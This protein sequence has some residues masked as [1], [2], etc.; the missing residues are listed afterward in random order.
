[1]ADITGPAHIIGRVAIGLPTSVATVLS[2]PLLSSILQQFPDSPGFFESLWAIYM[3]LSFGIGWSWRYSTRT[4]PA[5][6]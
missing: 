2:F 3:N 6:G 5:K 4:S 1:M